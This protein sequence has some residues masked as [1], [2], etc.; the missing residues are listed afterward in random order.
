MPRG[1]AQAGNGAA[2]A[3]PSWTDLQ[4]L[5]RA[6]ERR[7]SK[8]C[9]GIA[10]APIPQAEPRRLGLRMLHVLRRINSDGTSNSGEKQWESAVNEKQ[11][12]RGGTG[13][14]LFCSFRHTHFAA[15]A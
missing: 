11:E 2:A 10:L 8:R 15:G 1:T 13:V 6:W 7:A 3:G 9:E 5:M 12:K 4:A 14:Q